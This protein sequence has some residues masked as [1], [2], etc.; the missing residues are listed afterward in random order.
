MPDW[1]PPL[2]HMPGASA[3]SILAGL[4]ALRETCPLDILRAHIVHAHD[5]LASA[6]V[7]HDVDAIRAAMLHGN[8]VLEAAIQLDAA[9]SVK[10]DVLGHVQRRVTEALNRNRTGMDGPNHE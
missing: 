5:S 10:P 9:M 6:M 1:R 8:E 2:E 3:R 4:A 7:S